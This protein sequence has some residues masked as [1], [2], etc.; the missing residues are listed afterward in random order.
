MKSEKSE[1]VLAENLGEGYQIIF[2]SGEYSPMI[3]W[4]DWIQ[5]SDDEADI[6]VSVTFEDGSELVFEKGVLFKQ[7]WHEDVAK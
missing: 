4:V 6:Q 5:Q 1:H 2:E 3:E 7:I